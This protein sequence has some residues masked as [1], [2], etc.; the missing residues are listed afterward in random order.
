VKGTTNVQLSKFMTATAV[1][2]SL[3][4]VGCGSDDETES[5]SQQ[6]HASMRHSTGASE[7]Q[8]VDLAFAQAMIP[9]HESAVEMAQIA[10]DRA[11]SDFVMSL[12]DDIVRT[13]TA[14]IET[15]RSEESE[16]LQAGVEA[17]DLGMD[18]AMMGMDDDPSEL[19]EADPFDPAFI[20]MMIPH[21]DGAIAMAEMEL[22]KGSDP[23]LHSLAREI[24]SAQEREIA[25]MEDH[26]NA[27]ASGDGSHH[28]G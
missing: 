22:E 25:A 20:E 16:L 14:E 26:R 9:H 11:E 18:H 28:S 21:H 8:R 5:A 10:Q 23:E 24:I 6:D 7:A 3:S 2:A 15:L 17:G 19:R 13:Q 12:A 27:P 1:A 4:A